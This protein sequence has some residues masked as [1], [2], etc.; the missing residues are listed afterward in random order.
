M[1]GAH[2]IAIY[3][4]CIDSLIIMYFLFKFFFYFLFFRVTTMVNEVSRLGAESELQLPA[5]TTTIAMWD[6]QPTE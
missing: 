2:I 6:P 4:S 3:L 5:Y 1:L